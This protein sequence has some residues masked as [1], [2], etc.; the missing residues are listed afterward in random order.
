MTMRPVLTSVAVVACAGLVSCRGRPGEEGAKATD[1][2]GTQIAADIRKS[3]DWI[4]A[5]MSSSGY[6][7]DFTLESLKE[8]IENRDILAEAIAAI[9]RM[10]DEI[11]ADQGD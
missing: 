1:T 11:E 9:E 4:A 3:A 2:Q 6:K 7:A 8:V 10:S 5:A